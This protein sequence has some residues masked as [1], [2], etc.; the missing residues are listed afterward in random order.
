MD[1]LIR[2]GHQVSLLESVSGNQL[3][4]AFFNGCVVGILAKNAHCSVSS[5]HKRNLSEMWLCGV[6]GRKRSETMNREITMETISVR[7]G[8]DEKQ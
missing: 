7:I 4:S 5:M 2:L 6:L 3:K 8:K 1:D